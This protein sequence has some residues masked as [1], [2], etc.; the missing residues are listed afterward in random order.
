MFIL[1]VLFV[2]G[3]ATTT[4]TSTA[5]PLDGAWKLDRSRDVGSM[6]SLLEAMGVDY[7]TRLAVATL[8]MTDQYTVRPTE[9]YMQRYTAIRNTE[10]R[11]RV[12]VA[13][14][15]QD[16]LLGPVHSMVR[17][18]EDLDRV[19]VT[20]TRPRDQAI[21]ISLRHIVARSNP[22]MISCTMNFTLPNGGART[23]CVRY[24][25]KK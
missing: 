11:F 5:S 13:E 9:F 12:N 25:V 18:S 6:D 21:F 8:D 16:P 24:F 15:V 3:V 7:F 17:V 20:M 23:S 1:L 2:I 4:A 10:Q 22:P 14:E 19:M